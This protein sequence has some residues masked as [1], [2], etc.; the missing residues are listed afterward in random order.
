[1]K[2]T[3]CNNKAARTVREFETNMK[4][5]KAHNKVAF[6]YLNA[7][8][9]IH[10]VS[11]SVTDLTLGDAVSSRRH[12]GNR[13]NHTVLLA[14]P[15]K[16]VMRRPMIM[17]T[18]VGLS[19]P[20]AFAQT[21]SPKAKIQGYVETLVEIRIHCDFSRKSR[22]TGRMSFSDYTKSLGALIFSIAESSSA[23]LC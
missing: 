22:I 20:M 14:R 15:S 8:P 17:K 11:Y 4:Q 19:T 10:W 2:L 6:E 16:Q 21:T 9:H 1:M 13:V 7:I 5:L 18:I 3:L 23:T 12:I